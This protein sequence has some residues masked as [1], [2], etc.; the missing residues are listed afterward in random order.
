MS[1]IPTRRKNRKKYIIADTVL[2]IEGFQTDI[3][4]NKSNFE[5]EV[6][7]VDFYYVSRPR[8]KKCGYFALCHVHATPTISP[9]VDDRF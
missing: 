2:G 9:N 7:S 3:E 8:Q 1:L 6:S 5:E 4:L